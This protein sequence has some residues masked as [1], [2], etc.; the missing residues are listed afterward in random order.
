VPRSYVVG[1]SILVAAVGPLVASADAHEPAI[2][3]CETIVS[4][5]VTLIGKLSTVIDNGPPIDEP[6]EIVLDVWQRVFVLTV[7]TPIC[8]N[9]EEALSHK[10]I[11]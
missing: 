2:P 9:S 7:K 4:K 10:V 11:G 1:A 5:T 6:K 8:S 3:S